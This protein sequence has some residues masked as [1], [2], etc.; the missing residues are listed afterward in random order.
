MKEDLKEIVD[1]IGIS[2]TL[3]L[4][5]D[6]CREKIVSDDEEDDDANEE[7]WEDIANQLDDI[8]L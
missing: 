1:N 8:E 7:D 4:L 5:A 3:S 2:E 6:I